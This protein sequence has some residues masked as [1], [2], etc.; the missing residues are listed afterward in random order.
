MLA[1]LRECV[2]QAMQQWQVPGVAVAVVEAGQVLLCEGFGQRDIESGLPV[3]PKTLFAIG[4]CT[5]AFTAMAVGM[6]VDE[7]RLEWDR[8]I[9]AYLPDFQLWDSLATER[10]TI[11]DLLAHRTGLPRHEWLWYMTP[12]T[13]AEIIER[14]RYLQPSCPPRTRFQYNNLMFIVAGGLIAQLSS[15]WEAFIGERIFNPLGM[16]SSTFSTRV[17]QTNADSALPYRRAQDS[18]QPLPFLNVDT[19][20]PA[21]SINSNLVDLIPWV[22][23]HLGGGRYGEQQLI[24]PESLREMHS[25]QI[26]VQRPGIS[27][28]ADT[29]YG[30]GWQIEDYRGCKTIWHDGFIDG[31]SSRITFMPQ[32]Q[33]GVVVLANLNASALPTTLSYNFLDRLLGFDAVPRQSPSLAHQNRTPT[34]LLGLTD[35]PAKSDCPLAL[36]IGEYEHPGYGNLSVRLDSSC[37]EVTYNST[38]L[39]LVHSGGLTFRVRE[40]GS[41]AVVDEDIQAVIRE[42]R[43]RF[44]LRGSSIEGLTATMESAVHPIPFTR[45]YRA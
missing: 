27:Q 22:R 1:D 19:L 33:V 10:V 3:T 28:V 11:R 5:K 32:Q 13:R 38:R 30:L 9:K 12:L 4:S 7:E 23:L 14:L 37:L 2:Q 17:S 43:L 16:N 31:F 35:L 6:L 20:G 34:R 44:L 18:P 42:L 21:G 15:G 36:C 45:I 40:E 39:P 29:D 26:A 25:A 41:E 24:S 8:P